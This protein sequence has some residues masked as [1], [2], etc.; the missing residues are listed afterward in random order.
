MVVYK[1]ELPL[2]D[3]VRIE[4]PVGAEVLTVQTQHGVPQIWALVRPGRTEVRRFRV[5][6]TGHNI[7]VAGPYVGTFQLHGGGLVF[8][9]FDL[10]PD[11]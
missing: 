10:G 4:M 6:G 5:A 3:M 11:V 1:Y 9:V 2:E 7:S 8:H